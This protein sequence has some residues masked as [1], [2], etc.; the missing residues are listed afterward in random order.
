ME[1]PLLTHDRLREIDVRAENAERKAI[2]MEQER[3][4]WESK[5]EELEAKHKAT[6]QELEKLNA[7]LSDM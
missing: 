3:D 5:Y 6:A 4:E 1:A 7:E 2:R